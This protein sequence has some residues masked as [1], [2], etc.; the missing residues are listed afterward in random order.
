MKKGLKIS[1]SFN[2]NLDNVCA[3]H[4]EKEAIQ[5]QLACS[6]DFAIIDIV[7]ENSEAAKYSGGHCVSINEFK[8]IEREVA[9][10]MSV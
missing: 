5:L 3:W 6:E 2:V 8:R 10:Y 9:E 4:V 1:D 7:I